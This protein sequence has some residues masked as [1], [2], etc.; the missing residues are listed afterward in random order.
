MPKNTSSAALPTTFEDAVSELESLVEKM[1]N[2]DLPLEASLSAYARGAELLKFA[3][4]QL[5][6]ANAK[7]QKL[8]GEVL[9]TLQLDDGAA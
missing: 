1:E 5:D 9:K 7:L 6:S 2:G 3:Q 8:D 4:A